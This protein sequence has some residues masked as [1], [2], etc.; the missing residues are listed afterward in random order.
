PIAPVTVDVVDASGR[1]LPDGR[2]GELLI[3]GPTVALGYWGEP[4]RT[5]EQFVPARPGQGTRGYRTGDRVVRDAEGDLWFLGRIDDQL[6]LRGIRLEPGEVESTLCEHPSVR[7]AAVAVRRGPHGDER[8]HAFVVPDPEAAS[9][10]GSSALAA[11]LGR[12]RDV[13]DAA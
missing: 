2:P 13:H 4:G 12:W 10:L 11:Q 5:A 7:Q 6:K 3:A 1:S 9:S 8:L